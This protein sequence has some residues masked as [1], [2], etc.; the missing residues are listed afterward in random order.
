MPMFAQGDRPVAAGTLAGSLASCS[1]GGG[2]DPGGAPPSSGS[3]SGRRPGR[4]TPGCA[5]CPARSS[6]PRSSRAPRDRWQKHEYQATDA[7][8]LIDAASGYAL[9]PVARAWAGLAAAESPWRYSTTAS[10]STTPICSRASTTGTST[11]SRPSSCEGIRN[12]GV[13]GIIAARAQRNGNARCRV[14]R[15]SRQ[16][17]NLRAP[18][19]PRRYDGA[20]GSRGDRG[21]HRVG[22]GLTR[23]YGRYD[24]NPMQAPTY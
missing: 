17:R 23:S 5:P 22:G 14:Q 16:P 10:T 8:S 7:L 11:C 24:S 9:R 15:E 19:M 3:S 6:S 1:G 21:Q 4:R 2:D 20:G 13:A 18:R 12:G